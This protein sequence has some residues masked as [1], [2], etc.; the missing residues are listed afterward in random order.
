MRKYFFIVLALSILSSNSAFAGAKAQAVTRFLKTANQVD[1]LNTIDGARSQI[2]KSMNNLDSG[3]KIFSKDKM[4]PVDFKS[5]SDGSY[6][7]ISTYERKSYAPVFVNEQEDMI[8]LRIEMKD[9]DYRYVGDL[10]ELLPGVTTYDI[11][12]GESITT[13]VES[14]LFFGAKNE[15]D[16]QNRIELASR[17]VSNLY[18]DI[19]EKQQPVKSTLSRKTL[20]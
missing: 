11:P 8:H 13:V 12:N 17:V 9:M 14:N 10:K 4:S 20:N 5:F 15:I 6:L 1:K 2:L 7:K 19:L 16:M 3:F 18:K